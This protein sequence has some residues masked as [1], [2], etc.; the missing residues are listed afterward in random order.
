MKK[1]LNIL[2]LLSCFLNFK[3]QVPNTDLWLFKIENK[4]GVISFTK[5]VNV[6]NR[7]GYDNQPAFSTDGKKIYYVSIREDKQSDIY[8]YDLKSKK[9]IQF[10]KTPISE[11]SPEETPDGKFISA[12]VVEQDSAQ[13]IHF[14]NKVSGI[15]EKRFEYDSVGYYHLLNNDTCIYY[16]LTEPHS[17]RNNSAQNKTD[18][19][20][21]FSPTRTFKAI[22]RYT[23]IYGL[24]DT[25]KVTFYKYNFLLRKAEKYAD[26]PSTNEDICW[27]ASFGLVKSEGNKLLR[28]DEQKNEWLLLAD[29]SATG[30]KKITRFAFDSTNK[31]L[32]VVDN[33]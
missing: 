19:W 31:Y 4:K 33:I 32:V 23:L 15:H 6:T 26:Y 20:L 22:N 11:Y 10:T 7:E 1:N 2:F 25:S 29:L 13:R 3:G 17:L 12:V 21:G 9:N 5:P 28:F 30:I 24:K 27:N 8:Y 16:K 18:K 14:I